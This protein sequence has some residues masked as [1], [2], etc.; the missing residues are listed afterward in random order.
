ME[1]AIF[2]LVAV[3]MSK[4]WVFSR[5]QSSQQHTPGTDSNPARLTLLVPLVLFVAVCSAHL[6]PLPPLLL[7]YLSPATYALYQRSLP[8]W[9]ERSPYG[10]WVKQEQ[11]TELQSVGKDAKQ[12]DAPARQTSATA[13]GPASPAATPAI[14]I[15]S[16]CGSEAGAWMPLSLAPALTQVTLL[17]FLAYASF[18]LLVLL[19]P[20]NKEER[21]DS[22]RQFLRTVLMTI[23]SSGFLI[24][25]LAL[26]QRSFWNGKIL[27]FFVPEDWG[28]AK[29]DVIPRASGPFVNSDH[30]AN[31]LML[32]IPLLLS[33]LFS[34][35]MFVS[36]PRMKRFRIYCGIAL[37]VTLTGLLLSLS[38]G[39]WI[40]A[41]VGLGIF[42]WF[43]R[44]LPLQQRPQIFPRLTGFHVSGL[45]VCGIIGSAL[46]LLGVDDGGLNQISQR[47]DDTFNV[48]TGL[49]AR[50]KVW[51]S[52]VGMI[53]DFPIFGVGL[54]AWQE[55]FP[56]YQLPPWSRLRWYEAHNDYLQ[57][58]AETGVLGFGLLGWFF[59][60]VAAH[61]RRGVFTLDATRVP[62]TA[63]IMAALGGMAVHASGDF[64][65][66]IPANA[67]LFTALVALGL[68]MVEFPAG[69]ANRTRSFLPRSVL[70]IGVGML[71]CGLCVTALQQKDVPDRVNPDNFASVAEA[72]DNILAFPARRDGHIALIDL[73]EYSMSPAEL[74]QELEIALWLAP[75]D[76]EVRDQYV[77]ALL[78]QGQQE[79]ALR[80]MQQSVFHSPL[81]GTHFYL[82][83]EAIPQLDPPELLAV[84]RGM[85][86]ALVAGLYGAADG[87]GGLYYQ[88]GRF[89]EAG[90]IFDEA[91]QRAL[92]SDIRVRYLF[93][94]ARAYTHS[95]NGGRAE[96]LLREAIQLAPRES[97]L[98]RML[99][100][101]VYAA[102]KDFAAAKAVL[103]E[104]ERYGVSSL[105]ILF[106]LA[107]TAKQAGERAE[108]KAIL[109]QALAV[110]PRSAEGHVRLGRI[111]LE[112]RQLDR[113]ALS[114][115]K[116]IECQAN[117]AQAFHFLGRVEE[118]RYQYAAAQAAYAQ[119]VKL[120]PENTDFQHWANNLQKKMAAAPARATPGTDSNK[121]ASVATVVLPTALRK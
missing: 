62:V 43:L 55:L 51:Q 47:L 2:L 115:K 100:I 93:Y 103:I 73:Q 77:V 11:E 4:L 18:F 78:D 107:D 60:G 111:Y 61:I 28:D 104:G 94:A 71:A 31:Y 81:L 90:K 91:R 17:K 29:L 56:H 30:F 5:R 85:L 65:L 37:I 39:G 118:E 83:P 69:L 46:V 58:L 52:S 114:F 8:G 54:G 80:E 10:E 25:T 44:T 95:D 23:V 22:E 38:R 96:S 121:S 88:V 84:E 75:L 79:D 66:Q 45:V 1:A 49:S 102:R 117:M 14:D 98:Y 99:A 109:E 76:P 63:G 21:R 36:Q 112:D 13:S 108:A 116:A 110:A 92:R 48:D 24:A 86:Q 89:A 19:Y 64:S 87:L 7:S 12:E 113:A 20:V 82:T 6:V 27:W 41:G 59:C 50:M 33:G 15:C 16:H 119:A 72:R 101:D 40:G 9:P 32:V 26:V 97:S 34:P 106:S 120:A 70:S 3:W 68:R 57:C 67:M 74:R 53:R 35:R 105:P 42:F